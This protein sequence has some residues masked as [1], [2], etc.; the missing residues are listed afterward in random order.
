MRKHLIIWI[1][2]IITLCSCGQSHQPSTSNISIDTKS[3]VPTTKADSIQTAPSYDLDRY[4][5]TEYKYPD[6]AGNNLIIQNSF[7][8][9][10]GYIEP[11]GLMGYYDPIGTQYGHGV[12]W[13]RIINETATPVYLDIHFPAYPL[14]IPPLS[15]PYFR[16]FLPPD[17]MTLDK[18]D[19]YNYGITGLTA[20]LD[21]CF[22]E[23]SSLQLTIPAGEEYILYV[24]MIIHAPDGNGA[25]RTGFTLEGQ[26][27]SY[28]ISINRFGATSISCGQ[29]VFHE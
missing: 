18:L 19:L 13:T 25:I 24:A 9:G 8:K 16:L 1:C 28:S 14:T 6:A 4:L 3:V 29:M 15:I 5:H 27:L 2:I 7:P 20:F 21:A 10:G 23:P 12:F 26:E 22:Y 11:D 17:T